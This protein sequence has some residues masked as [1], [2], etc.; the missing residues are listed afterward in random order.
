MIFTCFI[1]LLCYPLVVLSIDLTLVPDQKGTNIVLACIAKISSSQIFSRDDQQLVRR[2]AYTETT[3]GLELITYS[4]SNNN[5]GIWQ[6]SESKYLETKSDTTYFQEIE[7]TF[8]INWAL[9]SWVD[10]R[11][12]FFSAL[13]ARLYLELKVNDTSDDFHFSTDIPS[14]SNFWITMFTNSSKTEDDYAAAAILLNEQERKNK[15]ITLPCSAVPIDAN[16]SL[17]FNRL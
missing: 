3:D 16:F 11:K 15:I 17:I 1:A 9:T 12:P 13:A 7:D 4:G 14:Q 6:L 10:L 5:G 2:I 8:K